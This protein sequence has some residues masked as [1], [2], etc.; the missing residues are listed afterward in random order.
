MLCPPKLGTSRRYEAL[1]TVAFIFLAM[2]FASNRLAAQWIKYPTPGVPRKADGKV[3]MSAPSPRLPDGKPDFSGIWTTGEPNTP[4][5]D[6]LS[7][8][9]EAARSAESRRTLTT[10]RLPLTP[11][12]SRLAPNGEYRC[13]SS[14]RVALST[15]ARADR[16]GAHRQPG[17]RRSPHQVL[18]G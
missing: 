15:L 9:K 11:Q 4:R 7:S 8:P 12:P 2:P 14:G 3:N 1:V 16:Q 5:T 6:G 10:R 18:A 17:Q 13:R